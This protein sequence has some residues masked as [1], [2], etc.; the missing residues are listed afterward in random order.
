M[1]FALG[2]G[3]NIRDA[4]IAY[5]RITDFVQVLKDGAAIYVLGA[6]CERSCSRRF[7]FMHHN[8]AQNKCIRDMTM[9]YYLDGAASNWNVWD[10]VVSK[11]S[12]PLYIQHNRY[13]TEQFTW[14]NRAYDIYSTEE[15]DGNNHHP[16][17]DTIVG[18]M[19][20]FPTLAEMFEQCP[21]ARKIFEQSGAEAALTDR[22]GCRY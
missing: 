9:G 6:N 13:V 8:F 17:R 20:I 3:I 14:H 18:E 16:E 7:N 22:G 11:T 2:E 15:I 21:A 5:N 10:N 19:H 4:E 12:R 1:P